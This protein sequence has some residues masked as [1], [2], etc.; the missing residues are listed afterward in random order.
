MTEPIHDLAPIAHMTIRAWRR[1]ALARRV[2]T[3]RIPDL[4]GASA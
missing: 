1:E 4:G 3:R 2:A